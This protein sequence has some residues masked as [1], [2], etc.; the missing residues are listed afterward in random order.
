MV[1]TLLSSLLPCTL[2]ERRFN[3]IKNV[4]GEEMELLEPF[5]LKFA[6]VDLLKIF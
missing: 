4:E 2:M 3:F 1:P 5:P 6:K